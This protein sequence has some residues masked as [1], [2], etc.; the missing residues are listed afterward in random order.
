MKSAAIINDYTRLL[1]AHDWFHEYSDDQDVWR[2]GVAQR[3]ALIKL[4]QQFD[5][6]YVIWN[7]IAP[8]QFQ[9]KPTQP[10]DNTNR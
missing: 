7:T 8:A 9:R 10:V 1:R 4:R 5:P 2:R 6:E 3:E